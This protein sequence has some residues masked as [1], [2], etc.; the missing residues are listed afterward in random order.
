MAEAK[1]FSFLAM[2]TDCRLVLHAD[3][4][5][6]DKVGDAAMG[7]VFRIEDKYSR[8]QRYSL[9]S[10]INEVAR[11]GGSIEVDGETAGLLNFAYACHQKSGGLF[12][13]TSGILRRA[14]DFSSGCLPSPKAIATLLP[15]IGLSK[16][17]WASPR[18]SFSVPGMELDFGGIGKEYAADRVADLCLEMG[19]N[20]GFVDMGGDIRI[21]GPHP[22]GEP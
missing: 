8:Y 9:L 5:L 22:D 14:W 12:D 4:S 16:V 11:S 3:E 20:A 7:E 18:L 19:V 15:F 13:I 17:H 2:G 21:I 10:Q 6:A 1:E